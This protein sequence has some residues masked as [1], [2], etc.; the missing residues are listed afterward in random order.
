MLIGGKVNPEDPLFTSMSDRNEGQR[1]TTRTLRKIAKDAFRSIGIE[2]KKLS[3]HSLR[4]FFATQSL[5]AGAPLLQVKEAMRHASI[6]TT[7]KY[8]HN[9]ERIEKG[10]E[11]YIDF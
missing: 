8:L 11:R 5:R 7:Q 2:K 6:E 10:A 4:H 1:L 9:I 3:A